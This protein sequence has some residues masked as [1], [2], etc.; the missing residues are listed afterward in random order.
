MTIYVCVGMIG[1]GK[2]TWAQ[3]K[4]DAGAFLVCHDRITED[5]HGRYRYEQELR[6]TY[7][8][9]EESIAW[10]A[11]CAGRDVI[12][13]R[14]NLTRESRR[15]WIKW[16]ADFI[17]L[18]TFED[19]GPSVQIVAVRFPIDHPATHAARRVAADPRGRSWD[20]WIKVAEHHYAQAQAEPLSADE[21]F[22]EIVEAPGS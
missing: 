19:K 18:N 11:L 17:S 12:V 14:T 16:V 3:P 5:I 6:D 21:G 2:S 8:R 15:R 10:A 1:S 9:I 20:E 7:R 22:D 13:D 4:A